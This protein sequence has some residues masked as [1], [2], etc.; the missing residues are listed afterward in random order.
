[1]KLEYDTIPSTGII[2]DAEFP[3]SCFFY[4]IFSVI[5]VFHILIFCALLF[6]IFQHVCKEHSSDL[7]QIAV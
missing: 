5:C 6:P 4:T 3:S 1:M 7:I 2:Y